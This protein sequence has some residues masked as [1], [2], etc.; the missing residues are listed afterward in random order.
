MAWDIRAIDV[1]VSIKDIVSYK[2][3]LEIERVLNGRP[4]ARFSLQLTGDLLIPYSIARKDRITIYARDGTTEIF[5]GIVTKRTV[6]TAMDGTEQLGYCECECSGYAAYTD[7]CSTSLTYT[8][9]VT[10][11]DVLNDLITDP[12]T[13]YGITL[14]PGQATGP[15]LSPFAWNNIRVS[16][17]LREL[18]GKAEGVSGD[19]Y[20]WTVDQT[21]R[22]RASIIGS[23]AAPL[24]I[25]DSS[26]D[27]DQHCRTVTWSDSDTVPSNYIVVTCGPDGTESVTQLWTAD[28]IANTWTADIAAAVGSVAP[29][30]V[31]VNG[32]TKT[33]GV[34]ANFTWNP[35]TRTLALGTASLPSAG[36]IIELTY[37][38]QFPFTVTATA[39]V[40]PVIEFRQ[41]E[42]EV[43]S[44]SAGQEIADGLLARMNTEPREIT[45]TTTDYAGWEVGMALTTA[46]PNVLGASSD[47][48]ITRVAV[49]MLADEFWEYTISATESTSYQGGY[50]EKWRELG[51]SGK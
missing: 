4:S 32:V 36:Q 1:P 14:D 37:T 43:R 21:A 13:N 2:H 3:G 17:A 51:V 39:G 10:L 48:I 45:V 24:D 20:A 46:M 40:T 49:Q 16:D 41:S 31:I 22:L 12:L 34:G 9:P 33:V 7:W 19:S 26:V 23:S 15:T 11:I 6:T 18:V 27:P 50:L 47:F 8:S 38:A 44:V 25:G 28:G 29:A 5:G 35:T 30:T 42:P